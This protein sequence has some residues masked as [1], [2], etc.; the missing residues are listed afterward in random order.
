M[1]D[2][3]KQ[4]LLSGLSGGLSTA[5]NLLT[6]SISR[7][8]DIADQTKLDDLAVDRADRINQLAEALLNLA[9]ASWLILSALSTA[10][11]SS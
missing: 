6:D 5:T 7:E 10:R 8:R 4:G 3:I 2:A 11:S 9:S 1:E